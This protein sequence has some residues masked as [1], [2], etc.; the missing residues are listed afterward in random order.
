[1]PIT[2]LEEVVRY[3]TQINKFLASNGIRDLVGDYGEFIVHS[4][5][6]GEKQSAVNPG[7]DIKNDKYGRVEVK[8]R[9]YELKQDGSVKKE[10]RAVGFKGKENNFDWLAHVILDTDFK[11]VSACL[12]KYDEV[13]PEVQRTKD[14]V[15]FA[16]SS[17]LPSSIDITET[18]KGAQIEFNKS[19]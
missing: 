16:T 4:A 6:G 14:K 2:S 11:V 13:W 8:T 17:K 1:M 19:I 15:G 9:K 12:A 7:F 5:I 18:L 10:N 3:Q